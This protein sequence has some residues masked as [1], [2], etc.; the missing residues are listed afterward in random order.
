[1][2]CDCCGK[3]GAVT[4]HVTRSFGRGK[5]ILVIEDVPMVVCPKCGQS[6]FTAETL[7]KLERLRLHKQSAGVQRV[8]PVIKYA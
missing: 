2:I 4:K 1:M 5:S 7:H 6:Y 8:A 3:K